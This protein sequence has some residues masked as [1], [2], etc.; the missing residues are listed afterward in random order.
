MCLVVRKI[1]FMTTNILTP[2]TQTLMDKLKQPLSELIQQC[3]HTRECNIITDGEWIE[4]GLTKAM[5]NEST[6]RGFLQ[7]IIDSGNVFLK[8]SHFFETL[9]SKRRLN[10]C[11]ELC[12]LLFNKIKHSYS[13]N[14][15]LKQY[16]CL[17]D[18][19]I[20]AGDG[21]YHAAAVHD[22]AKDGKKY[23]VQHFYTLDLRTHALNHLTQA[24]VSGNRKKEHDM[25]ALKR[26]EINKLRNNAPTGRK[27]IFIWDR[28][29]I[30][31]MQWY[32]WK[33]SGGIY[34][35]SRE[36]SNMELMKMGNLEFDHTLD[37]NKGVVT[38][39]IVGS[40]CGVSFHRV[41]Y[42]CPISGRLYSFL[43]NLTQIPPG[44]IAY[45]YLLRWDVE[46]V[47]DEI[48]NKMEEKKA[49]ATS[50]TAKNMQAEFICLTH[51]L[52][53]I[54]EKHLITEEGIE[55][56]IE[57][58]RKS[59]RL[60][61]EIKAAKEKGREFP[62][63]LRNLKRSTQ[64]SVKFIRWLRNNIF[65]KTSWRASLGSLRLVYDDF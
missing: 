30:D 36:K 52:M 46:K 11:I 43:T 56:K 17:D 54:M 44:L 64:R 60:V 8:R 57:I 4:I 34:F 23:P 20:Y 25:R 16:P 12:G 41:K 6:G 18:Y 38:Y 31:F 40:N 1:F 63:H 59:D 62:F 15:P 5:L 48:K 50:E 39:E 35:I 10:F 14:D 37:I 33:K 26:M 58:N 32:K 27:V 61:K 53:L 24:D 51:N 47:F 29:G 45:L 65:N 55:N 3:K 42:Q 22:R 28:A 2:Q 13:D 49:W 9:K 21:H 7:R 19:D